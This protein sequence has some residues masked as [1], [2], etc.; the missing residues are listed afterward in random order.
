M[1]NYRE[2]NEGATY[3]IDTEELTSVIHRAVTRRGNLYLLWD[4]ENRLAVVKDPH[5]L[6][7]YIYDAEYTKHYYIEGQR[8]CSK[9]GGGYANAP[10]PPLCNFPPQKGRSLRDY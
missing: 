7:N 8:V 4:E 10:A 5:Y 6:S 3:T 9:L 1:G 2:M